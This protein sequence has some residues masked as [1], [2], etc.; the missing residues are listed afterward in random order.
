M[1]PDFG[2]GLIKSLKF[3]IMWSPLLFDTKLFFL[4]QN[5]M[6]Q[7]IFFFLCFIVIVG[8]IEVFTQHLLAVVLSYR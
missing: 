5:E 2:P 3:E 7:N 4:Q 6:L 8:G 1:Y